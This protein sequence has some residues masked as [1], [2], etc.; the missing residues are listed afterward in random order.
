MDDAV[1]EIVVLLDMLAYERRAL[2]RIARDLRRPR[3]W[4]FNWREHM[5]AM[6]I[7][8]DNATAQLDAIANQFPPAVGAAITKAHD[9]G[10]T[11]GQAQGAADPDIGPAL[12]KFETQLATTTAA[13][14]A[15]IAPPVPA[16]PAPGA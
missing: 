16:D 14:Q 11:E 10:V 5:S 12:D 1:A 3:G 8:V 7:R 9:A 6:S 13:L 15:S 2:R 4:F